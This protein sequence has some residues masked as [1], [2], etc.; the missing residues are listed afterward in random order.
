M[1]D[2][3]IPKGM[4]VDVFLDKIQMI[5]GLYDPRVRVPVIDQTERIQA[6]RY[7]SEGVQAYTH[8]PQKRFQEKVQAFLKTSDL[9]EPVTN[10]FDTFTDT[11]NFDMLWQPA[12]KDASNRIEA[13]RDFWETLTLDEGSA[14]QLIPEGHSVKIQTRSGELAQVKVAKFGDGIAWT[15]EMIRFRKIG[16]MLDL[17]EDFRKG[18]FKDKAD[19]HYNLLTTSAGAIEAAD[20][21][22]SSTLEK[23]INTLNNAAFNLLNGLKDTRN[24]PMTTPLL[25]YTTPQMQ[26]RLNRAL[27][28]VSQAF[29]GSTTRV[30]YN[31]TPVYT[32]N[33]NLPAAVTTES[34][35]GLLVVPGEKIQAATIMQPTFFN[36]TD[37]LSLSF[38]QTAFSYYGAG[39][40]DINQIRQ[41]GFA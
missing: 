19:R 8:R 5:T 36:D 3:L 25:L 29:P 18:Y 16:P 15:D 14:W 30:T 9:P 1:K 37:I 31:I 6:G 10:V 33:D 28:E 26:T 34:F 22:G 7:F 11:E 13:G 32:F 24:L 39:V 40:L 12:F 20:D 35:A 4:S 2:S 41:V 23:D 27:A 17:A 21:T 38:I